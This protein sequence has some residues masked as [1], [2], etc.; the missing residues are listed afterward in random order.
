MPDSSNRRTP[1]AVVGVSALFPGSPDETGFWRD[2][3]AGRDLIRDVPATHWLVEDYYDPNPDAPDK[4]YARRGAFLDPTPFDALAFGVPPS[5]VPATDTA[6]LLALIVAQR[7]LEDAARGQFSALDRERIG[8]ILGVT[9]GQELLSTMASRLQRPVWVKALR[10]AGVPEGKVGEIC[11]RIAGHYVP[12]QESTFPGLL[13]NVVAGRIANRFDLGGTNCVTD[14]ACASAFSAVSMA[15][16]ELCLGQAD[17]VITGGVDTLNDIFMFMCFSKTPALSR[18]GDCRPFSEEADGTLLGEGLAMVALK[19]LADAEAAGD[20]IYAVLQGLGSSSDGR[21]KS[22]YAPRP[23]GQALALRRAYAAAGY[24]PGTVELVEAHGT[25]TVVG[26][27]AEFEALRETFAASGRRDRGWCALGS[28][29]SQIGHTKAAAGAAGLFKAVMA[30]HHGILPPTIKVSRPNPAL[31]IGESPFYLNT[32]ARPWVRASDHPR[33]ASVSSFGFGGSNFHLTLEEYR[34]P[35]PRAWR[36][37]VAASELVVFGAG[38]PAEL[39]ATLDA[40]EIGGPG[41][42]LWLARHSQESCPPG[43]A[44]RVAITAESEDDLRAKV[45]AAAAAIART[46]EAAFSLPGGVHYGCAPGAGGVAF[47]FPGQGSQYPG[48]G[49]EAAMLWPEALAAW[50]LA[51]DLR[52]PGDERLHDVVF[53]RPVFTAE[54][55]AAQGERLQRT[56]WA[57][58]GIGVASLAHLN[59]L[60]AVG[61]RPDCVG[62]HSFG[63]VVA[64]HAAGVFD[65]AAMVA[66]ARRRGELMA[67]A[68]A[69]PGAMTAAMAA[70]DAVRDAVAGVAEVVVANHNAPKQVVLSGPVPAIEGAEAALQGRGIKF[71]R[72]PV[73][74]AFHSPVVAAAAGAFREYLSG[75]PFAAPALPVYANSQ[76][77]PYPGDPQ[78]VRE[79]LAS[80]LASPVR[81]VEQVEAMYAAGVRTFVECGPGAVLTGLVDRILAG[82]AYRAVA[83]EAKGRDGVT[84]FHDALGRLFA[85]GI[86]LDLAGL[87][88]AFAP[89]RD[90]RREAVPALALPLCGANYGKPYPPPGGAAALPPP[91]PEPRA[92]APPAPRAALPVPVAPAAA[93]D[94]AGGPWLDAYREAQRETLEAHAAWEAMMVETHQAFLEASGRSLATLAA[95]GGGAPA[96]PG[97][98]TPFV[99]AAFPPAVPVAAPPAAPAPPVEIVAGKQPSAPPAAPP[100]DLAGLL[101]AVVAEKTGY[102][103]EMLNPGMALEADLGIDSIKRVEILAAVRERVPDLPEIEPGVVATLGTLGEIIGHL[104]RGWPAAAAASGPDPAGRGPAST[105]GDLQGALLAV[106]AE[107]TGYPAD[108]LT[109]E[110]ALEA[111]LGI[112]SIKRVEIFSALRERFPGLGEM[113]P[114]AMAALPTLGAIVAALAGTRAPDAGPAVPPE[115]VAAASPAAASAPIPLVERFAVEAV[116]TPAP[117]LVTPGLATA[118][119]VVVVGGAAG[120]DAALAA[121]LCAR[122]VPAAAADAVP[123]DADAVLFLGG[124]QDAEDPAS[125]RASVRAAFRCAQAL[126]P[127]AGRNGAVFVTVQDTGGDFGLAGSDRAWLGGVA[128]VAKTAAAEWPKASVKA[129]DV[130]RAGRDAGQLA[131]AI[132]LELFTGGAER[133]VGI[134]ADG[135]RLTLHLTPRAA[136]AGA[137][138]LLDDR[139][140]VVATGGGRG[141]TAACLVALAR[142]THCRIALLGR[143][144]LGDEPPSC[145]GIVDE[146]GLKRALLDE[147]GA[148][149]Q[150]P[151]PAALGARAAAILAA[152][153]VRA[154]LAAIRAAG[155][156]A[157]YEV[158]DVRDR[159]ALGPALAAVRGEWGPVTAVVHGAGVLADR[160]I[161]EKSGEQF[162]AV[163]DT[164]VLGLAALLEAVAGDPLRALLLFSSVAARSG[165]PGQCDYAAANE[166]LNKVAALEARRRGPACLARAVG[167][168]P[169]AGGMVTPALQ[170]RFT[171]RGVGLLPVEAGAAAFVEE[172]LDSPGGPAEVVVGVGLRAGSLVPAG[173]AATAYDVTVLAASHPYLADHRIGDAPVLPVVLALEWFARAAKAAQPDLEL[174]A[175]RDVRVLKGARLRG[176]FNG[177]DRFT[178]SCRREA[179][180]GRRFALELRGAG[181]ALHYTATAE[182]AEQLPLPDAVPTLP[183]APAA[184]D[185]PAPAYSGRELFHGPEFQVITALESVSA[186]GAAGTLVG[187]RDRGWGGAWS[188]DAAALDGGLQLAMLWTS[189]LLG[190]RALPTSFGTFRPYRAGAAPGPFRCV[191]RGRRVSDAR[192]LCD[193]AFLA[194]DGALVYELCGV[195]VHRRPDPPPDG[196]KR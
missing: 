33:R 163:F 71:R 35:A 165:N 110:M 158:A 196:P 6:Q 172:L 161:A 139:S 54:E 188:T 173:E 168:G 47:L 94:G 38:T 193:I 67:A 180:P 117:G 5:I 70:I 138:A 1:I 85:A 55:R 153:E 27:A 156:Q 111:D 12:W 57:Q 185:S 170:E 109:L 26:D 114:S 146:A 174:V 96:L 44:A 160:L 184:A 14:A 25:G 112:D 179:G 97:S 115:A 66:V 87:W 113:E 43:A 118:R 23:E 143:T 105:P 128:G 84:A 187:T 151:S 145:R 16:N 2:I 183:C 4:T 15:V 91:N 89:A 120:A 40:L 103:A 175:C 149:G 122:G 100:R 78:A 157:R 178:V 166:V 135:R 119:R 59:L 147:A 10:E 60:A 195:E 106:V 190:G 83:L 31:R 29:K 144:P 51:A 17:L 169:W 68:V 171:A 63:E 186:E 155:G 129:L 36:K 107:K 92:D 13:G 126:A 88:K 58:P 49:A 93:P 18:T 192:T 154:T 116:E 20:R 69:V 176:F 123:E 140:V 52:L 150:V 162:D 34:G 152:R 74:T 77:A 99:R 72:L 191:L 3:L 167:W 98:G 62:G 42:L 101:L 9:S 80:Q 53:P 19:R 56:E 81:F 159:D 11:D 137:P 73:A 148:R 142:R 90:P 141:V 61:L 164:K 46:P 48:M 124:L 21:A 95:L 45:A 65:A 108:M 28:V 79:L 22:V 76:A 134:T 132:A 86:R 104:E 102:P 30:L 133:E 182:M 136:G 189:H 177:G 194:A 37:R 82:R 7:V 121:A 131:E 181:G 127:R 130:A 8:V 24:G 75:L 39:I 41:S 64:L 125:A 50:D 32:A